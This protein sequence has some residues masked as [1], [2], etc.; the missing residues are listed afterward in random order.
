M[1][2]VFHGASARPQDG[3]EQ[4][5]WPRRCIAVLHGDISRRFNGSQSAGD[6]PATGVWF[7]PPLLR[8]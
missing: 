7:L 8:G 5:P 3:K 6:E 1:I 4:R 2:G